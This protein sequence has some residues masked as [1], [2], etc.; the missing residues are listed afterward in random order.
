MFIIPPGNRET[1][2]FLTYCT[3]FCLLL[4]NEST[5]II[6]N[7]DY[8]VH[9]YLLMEESK[10]VHT[11]RGQPTRTTPVCP[12]MYSYGSSLSHNGRFLCVLKNYVTIIIHVIYIGVVIK[13]II[14]L[15]KSAVALTGR[16]FPSP[17]C[18]G[19]LSAMT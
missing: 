2:P 16:M 10:I 3:I 8:L 14:G 19:L 15:L 4:C 7:H 5:L 17:C 6:I 9:L 11:G 18:K 13:K 1:K 12:I